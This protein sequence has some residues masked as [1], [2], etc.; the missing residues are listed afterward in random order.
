MTR[1]SMALTKISTSTWG[2]LVRESETNILGGGPAGYH[3]R[4]RYVAHAQWNQKRNVNDEQIIGPT[5]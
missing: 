5:E 1:Q 4:L 3:L 2:G